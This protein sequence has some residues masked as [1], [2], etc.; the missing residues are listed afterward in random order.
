MNNNSEIKKSEINRSKSLFN[1]TDDMGLGRLKRVSI[2]IISYVG[3][4]ILVGLET[5]VSTIIIDIIPILVLATVYIGNV[6]INRKGIS[7]INS[8]KFKL[9][10][11]MGQ[12]IA[13]LL[14]LFWILNTVQKV[15]EIYER[16]NNL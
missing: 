12:I 16:L 11:I 8:T 5:K 1:N 6:I 9:V 7:L 15:F 14:I 2:Y 10:D 3:L 4:G 13:I